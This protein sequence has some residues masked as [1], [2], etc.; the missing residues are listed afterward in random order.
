MLLQT[1]AAGRRKA[2]VSRSTFITW[3]TRDSRLARTQPSVLVTVCT[4]RSSRVTSTCLAAKSQAQTPLT[5]LQFD[6]RIQYQ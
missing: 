4:E 3:S 6:T 1:L 2:E 5:H